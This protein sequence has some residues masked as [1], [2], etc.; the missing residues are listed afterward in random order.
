MGTVARC[1]CLI[2]TLLIAGSRPSAGVRNGT[3]ESDPWWGTQDAKNIRRAIEQ[4]RASGD[5]SAVEQAAQ[6][7]YDLAMQ[8]HARL[9]A[10]RYLTNAGAARSAM[11]RYRSAMEAY[12]AARRLAQT[13]GDRV[14]EG[15]ILTNL[16]GLYLEMGDIESAAAFAGKAKLFVERHPYFEY[17]LTLQ[18]GK[19]YAV[20]GDPRAEPAFIEEIEAARAHLDFRQEARGWDYLGDLWLR[21]GQIA[22]ADRA[23]T[24]AFRVRKFL[25]RADLPFSYAR[26][27][28]V[29]LAE[30]A[31]E[32]A[33]KFTDL[34][35]KSGTF[36][37]FLLEHQRGE[38]RLAS[39]DRE[40]ALANFETAAHL[41]SAWRKE[42]L[43]ALSTLTSS[44]IEL[45]KRVF[46]SLVEAEARRGFAAKAFAALEQNRASSLRE[47]LVLVSG[48]QQ[49]LP[50]RYWDVLERLREEQSRLRQSVDQRS[51]ALD[52][53]K[54]EL[55]EIESESGLQISTK[56][57]EIFF[58]RNPLI[59]FQRV[60]SKTELLLSFHLGRTESYMW[61]VTAGSLTMN[62]LAPS[63][64]I[65]ASV[66]AFRSAVREGRPEV[67]RIGEQLYR[68]LFGKLSPMEAARRDWIISAD[69]ALFEAPLA[70]L[71]TE[72]KGR[73]R[74][75]IEH[76]SLRLVPGAWSLDEG[77]DRPAGAWLGVG[78]PIYNTADARWRTP[79]RYLGRFPNAGA[80]GQLSRLAASAQ[81]IQSSAQSWGSPATVLT[82]ADATLENFEAAAARHPSVIHLATHVL[83][84][85]DRPAQALIAFGLNRAGEPQFLTT[86]DVSAMRV[87]DA[88]VVMTGCATGTGEIQRGAGLIGLT[89]AWQLA[90]ARA[91]ISTLW[92]VSDSSGDIFPAF[93]RQ[94]HEA[95]PAE[96]LRRSQVEMIA[97]GTWRASPRYWAAYQVTGGGK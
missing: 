82:G 32:D 85:T 11:F 72:Q 24:E 87:P 86:S 40:G 18:M 61:A 17:Q 41:A 84:P 54:T 25:F 75:L 94:L 12:V 36:L 80:N 96:A 53:F 3:P 6:K 8:A 22:A 42:A 63:D 31:L 45:E 43:P 21:R 69:D 15:A 67:A 39:G 91:V 20:T 60:L 1:L 48:W 58:S 10:V 73:L 97:S 52:R 90:G 28:S 5:Y 93:Y 26:L 14:D 62:R 34:A 16:S 76:H 59:H 83:T 95:S 74:Y 92:A 50:T 9:P 47:S 4:A 88:L 79:G 30:N 2:L 56:K 89:R 51:S 44:N 57:K 66:D 29:R 23:F 13:I 78:D 19:L 64:E 7:G 68:Q 77:H 33:A 65:R 70:A 37:R 38:I 46:E 71:V 27:G 49:R 81:E 35:L 55:T